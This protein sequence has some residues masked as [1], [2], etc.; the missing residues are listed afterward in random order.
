MG[1]RSDIRIVTTKDGFEKLKEFVKKYLEEKKLDIKEYNLLEELDTKADGK[2]QCY[3]GWNG[4]KW[5]SSSN[6]LIILGYSKQISL[7]F[8]P[9]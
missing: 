6:S 2:E 5:Y 1:Y 4:L 9:S 3:F 7:S 8:S